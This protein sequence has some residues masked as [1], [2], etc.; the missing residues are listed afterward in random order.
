MSDVYQY[1]LDHFQENITLDTIG[2][3]AKATKKCSVVTLSGVPI[4]RFTMDQL[5]LEYAQTFA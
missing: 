2:E 4:R 5:R 3:I 1:T